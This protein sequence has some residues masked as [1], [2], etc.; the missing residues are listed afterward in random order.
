M[1]FETHLIE[2]ALASTNNL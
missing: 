1:Q 2:Q